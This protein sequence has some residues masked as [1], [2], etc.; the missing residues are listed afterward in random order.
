MIDQYNKLLPVG[1]SYRYT[2]DLSEVTEGPRHI[3][4][5][6]DHLMGIDS[7]W[8]AYGNG[9]MDFPVVNYATHYGKPYDHFW[10]SGFG[11]VMPDR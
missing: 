6:A 4:V 3:H 7:D 1:T 8:L 11:T 10:S 2:F 9:G 5:D